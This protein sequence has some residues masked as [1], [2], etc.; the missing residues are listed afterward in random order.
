[1]PAKAPLTWENWMARSSTRVNAITELF[2]SAGIEH[3]AFV[4]RS[5]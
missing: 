1:M 5:H 3:H 2:G 4:E